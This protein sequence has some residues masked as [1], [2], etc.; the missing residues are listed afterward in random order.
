MADEIPV[1]VMGMIG[2]AR[3]GRLATVTARNEPRVVPICFALV[4]VPA[5]TIVSVLDEKPKR[6][7][8]GELARVRNLRRNPACSLVI[9]HYEEDWQRL[10]FV[11]VNGSARV[12]EPGD[13]LHEMALAA[14]R[15][16]YPQY[17]EMR[18]ETRL[19]IAIEI[20]AVT[21]WRGDGEAWR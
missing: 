18:L 17:R 8:D 16:K 11:Q 7:T 9:D 4:E 1:G 15:A 3:L 2:G 6:V 5:P 20:Q 19:A 10:W 21:T 12:L 13:S 14:L